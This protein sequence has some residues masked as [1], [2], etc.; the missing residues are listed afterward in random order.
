[1]RT[2][3]TVP[4]IV[5]L[6]HMLHALPE[7][8]GEESKTAFTI[9]HWLES[10]QPDDIIPGLGGKGFAAVFKGKKPGPGVMFRAELDALPIPESI[11]LEYS[12]TTRGI[13]HKCGH[14]G[15]MAMVAGIAP[16]LKE[17]RPEKGKVIL[18]F[19]PAEETGEGAK[20]VLESKQWK[21]IK[22]DY[23]FALHNLPGFPIGSI[24]TRGGIFAASSSGLIIELEGA[25][26][27]A[28]NPEHGRSPALAVAELINTLST[29]VQFRIPMHEA[30][31]VTVIHASFGEIAF[32]T[33]PGD[34]V[35]LATL[36]TYSDQTMRTLKRECKSVAKQIGAVHNLKVTTSWTEEFP[37]T[38]NHPEC[39]NLIR[40]AARS[41]DQ[42]LIEPEHPFA[43]S[44]DF[45]HY[46]SSCK[47]AM[48]GLGAGVDHPDLHSKMYDF[49]DVLLS[50][51]IQLY[52]KIIDLLL[53]GK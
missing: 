40:T 45:G 18:L 2:Q 33:S 7:L 23:V 47:G 27:H 10:Y 17:K 35:V 41:L 29:L 16:I 21:E 4:E 46:T 25:T 1:M 43:F 52:S 51:G 30:A 36:R 8:A 12:S 22:P 37:A 50:D 13:S 19:Q 38:D 14:D 31:K 32:G 5:S 49:P 24:I 44:E 15:H 3:V 53:N 11:D 42:P 6:R 48:F 9:S 20:A 39:I 28:A 34:G 26:A